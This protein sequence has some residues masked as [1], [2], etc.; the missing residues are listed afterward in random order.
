MT[1]INVI[2]P[3]ELVNKHLLAEYREFPRIFG[4]SKS[5]QDKGITPDKVQISKEYILGKGHV[6]FFSDKGAFL[7]KRQREIIKELVERGYNIKHTDVDSLFDGLN[8]EWMKD[9]TPTQNDMIVNKKRIDDRLKTMKV[10][11]A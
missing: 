3:K 6:K 5:L 9:Y 10:N 1:R 2:P 7:V 4:Y 11:A 8:I